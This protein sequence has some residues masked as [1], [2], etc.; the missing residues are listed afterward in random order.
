MRTTKVQKCGDVVTNSTSVIQQDLLSM[1]YVLG[2]ILG[3]GEMEVSK[4]ERSCFRKCLHSRR[5]LIGE[6]V[7]GQGS[8]VHIHHGILLSH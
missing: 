7:N 6:S 3:A 1:C 4:V 8:C 5:Q 2:P